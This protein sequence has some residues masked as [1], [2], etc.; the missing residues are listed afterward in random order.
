MKRL[1]PLLALCLCFG[2]I[3]CNDD[4][5]D[6]LNTVQ[7]T[8]NALG[9]DYTGLYIHE[10]SEKGNKLKTNTL[11]SLK[12]GETKKYT[13]EK[14]CVKVKVFAKCGDKFI[15]EEAN[16]FEFSENE[17]QLVPSGFITEE[18]YNFYTK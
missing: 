9:S 3:G 12:R 11:Y 10:L 2:F 16:C 8:L 7:Y 4:K 5:E 13:S 17:I 14:G 18:E 15:S 1:F 6:G